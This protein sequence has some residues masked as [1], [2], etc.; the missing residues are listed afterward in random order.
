MGERVRLSLRVAG[1]SRC[2]LTAKYVLSSLIITL[3]TDRILQ[4]WLL[5]KVLLLAAMIWKWYA[6]S[7][8]VEWYV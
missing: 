7:T 4:S 6:A 5:I 2:R 8:K 3:M 1:N